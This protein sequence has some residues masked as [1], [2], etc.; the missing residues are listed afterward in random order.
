M[1]SGGGGGGAAP[2]LPPQKRLDG[3]TVEEGAIVAVFKNGKRGDPASV[4]KAFDEYCWASHWMMNVGDVKGALVRTALAALPPGARVLEF[5]GYCGY[6]AVLIGAA[7]PPGGKL[8]SIEINPVSAA[9]ATK[10]VE[11][12]GLAGAV[13]VMVSDVPAALDALLAAHGTGSVDAVFIDHAKE[14]YLRDL[15]GL[16]ARRLLRVGSLLVADNILY[17]G[18][19]DYLAYVTSSPA[20]ATVTHD[21]HLE[22]CADSRDV[23]AVSTVRE[24]V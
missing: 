8:V 5:G 17:P 20:Y 21:T 3:S 18:A 15:H 11:H 4:L 16:E 9:L 10:V 13:T 23:V 12:A 24:L 19:P 22:Y 6:S 1:A 2:V 14:C 7:L